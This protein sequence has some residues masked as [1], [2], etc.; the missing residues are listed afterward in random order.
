MESRFKFTRLVRTPSSE[1]YLFWDGSRRLGQ[2]D[3]HF[4]QE[5]VHA[6]VIF[7]T[8]LSVGEEE[9]LLAQIDD[10]IVSSYLPRFERED[11]VA[12]V[13]RGEEISRYTDCSGPMDDID[14]ED[15]DEDDEDGREE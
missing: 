14:D 13:F 8:D 4:A 12:H 7:E 2:V 11:F 9:D 3:V 1:I 5:T 6:T 10:D 15:E